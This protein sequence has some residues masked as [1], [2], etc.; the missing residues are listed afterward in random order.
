[1]LVS[2]RKQFIYTKTIKTGG[3]S[4]EAYFE[5]YCF[6]DREYEFL[7]ARPQYASETGIVGF[8]GLK[9][10]DDGIEWYNHMPAAEIKARLGEDVWN[11]YVKFCVVRDPFD[12]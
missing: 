3:T 10:P 8:R 7:H 9:R 5:P 2:H 11:R 1:M 6:P 4:V 12:K